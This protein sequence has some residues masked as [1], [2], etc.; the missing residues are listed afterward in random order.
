MGV[1]ETAIYAQKMC[2]RFRDTL[3]SWGS[4]LMSKKAAPCAALFAFNEC[5]R[6][7]H[8]GVLIRRGPRRAGYDTSSLRYQSH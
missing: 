3:S 6:L 1:E 5:G 8:D 7:G 4:P 2:P